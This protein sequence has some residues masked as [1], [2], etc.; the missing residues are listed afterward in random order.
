MEI[1]CMDFWL[2]KVPVLVHSV[3]HLKSALKKVILFLSILKLFLCSF[4]FDNVILIL[5]SWK[6]IYFCL[7]KSLIQSVGSLLPLINQI[8]KLILRSM[9]VLL[10]IFQLPKFPS[11]DYSFIS[12]LRRGNFH[13]QVS[14]NDYIILEIV[15][16]FSLSME[17]S[18]LS[19]NCFCIALSRPNFKILILLNSVER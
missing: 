1:L 12:C 14:T 10:K 19:L 5:F 9:L 2:W 16:R 15:E 3:C 7:S 4:N 17:L 13:I 8:I 6:Y 18:F 11:S